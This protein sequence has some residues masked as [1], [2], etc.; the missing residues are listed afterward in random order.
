MGAERW[1]DVTVTT[2]PSR[3]KQAVTSGA[4]LNLFL[5]VCLLSG[6]FGIAY[7]MFTFLHARRQSTTTI[8][9]NCNRCLRCMKQTVRHRLLPVPG[10]L[11]FLCALFPS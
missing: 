1:N 2:I 8:L 7:D 10:V 9:R 3:R 4:T 6:V 5:C 11:F